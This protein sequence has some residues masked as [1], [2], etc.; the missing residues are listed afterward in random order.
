MRLRN[1]IPKQSISE[2]NTAVDLI[3]SKC[4]HL[5]MQ[6]DMAAWGRIADI[7]AEVRKIK[8]LIKEPKP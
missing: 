6:T 2:I 1:E 5:K 7:E 8:R 3:I 4:G